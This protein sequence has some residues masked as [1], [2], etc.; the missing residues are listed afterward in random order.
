MPETISFCAILCIISLRYTADNPVVDPSELAVRQQGYLDNTLMTSISSR[1]K[2]LI[3]DDESSVRE[4]L[5]LILGRLY[6]VE[7]AENGEQAL[8]ILRTQGELARGDEAQDE[9]RYLPDLLLLD[10]MMPGIDG[11]ELL[12]Q[13]R[14][15]YPSIQVIMLT[16][17]KAVKNIVQAMK[18][19]AVDYLSK[20]FDVDELLSLIKDTLERL[21]QS[22]AEDRVRGAGG[23]PVVSQIEGDFG[24]VVGTHPLM[25]ELYQKIDQ[26][27]KRDTTILINGESGTGKE[28]IARE[29]HNRSRRSNGPFIAL[30]CA[31]IPETLI[32]SELFGHE[33][34]AFTHAVDR[35]IGHFELADGGTL[36]LD[37][38]GE[39]SLP[40][41]V[42]MLRFLQEQE[43]YR[44]GRSKPILV[45]V[46]ILAATNRSLE[47][48]IQ[49]GRFRQDLYYRV[50][51]VALDI[52]ALRKRKED[53]GEL[54]E[55]FVQKLS[56][57][58]GGKQ[59]KLSKEAIEVL[60]NYSW[61]G[62]VRE[63]ENVIESVLALASGETIQVGDLPARLRATQSQGELADEV[64]GGNIPFEEAERV[65]ETEIILKALEKTNYVQTRA[66]ELLGI[67]RRIL[68]YKM[69]KLG[70]SDVPPE[71]GVGK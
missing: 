50:N 4:S 17:S 53:I 26:L 62:N 25:A 31:A 67:S 9:S 28:L 36:F 12:K 18:I 32:E 46:R 33:K 39:L 7:I 52:P 48:A 11:I 43:F 45:D 8:E 22:P 15:L 60:N 40:V 68:K 34:G 16:A 64:L 44:V 58:Y 37:E 35:R 42:K 55:H 24:C 2:V 14:S 6:Q 41:Q 47:T 23:R 13:V 66:A 63:L 3:V 27:A 21:P 69:D 20:P 29:I 65:F 5:Q 61:P 19:G 71:G 57:M 30:N 54:A 70:I 38:I 51:V 1:K 59:P 49:E 56:P 10:V